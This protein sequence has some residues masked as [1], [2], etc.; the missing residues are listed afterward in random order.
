MLFDFTAKL[1][2]FGV[3]KRSS[4]GQIQL[5]TSLGVIAGIRATGVL[6]YLPLDGTTE[7]QS[8]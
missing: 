7:L 1:E 2:S 3:I 8:S 6:S 4:A 5:E